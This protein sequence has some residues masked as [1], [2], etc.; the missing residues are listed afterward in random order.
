MGE[1][2]ALPPLGDDAD[3]PAYI[4]AEPSVGYRMAKGEEQER[5]PEMAWPWPPRVLLLAQT[6]FRHPGLAAGFHKPEAPAVL[7]GASAELHPLP[8][9]LSGRPFPHGPGLW[10]LTVPG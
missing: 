5:E 1:A 4:F 9:W 3:N 6:A 7:A 10:L 2:V 8:E